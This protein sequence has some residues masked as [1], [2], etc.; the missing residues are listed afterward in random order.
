MND[1]HSHVVFGVDDGAK[2]EEM[3]LNMI[4]MAVASGTK[5]LIATPHYVRGRFQVSRGEI[6]Q[7]IDKLRKLVK[8][9]GIKIEIFAGQEVYYSESILQYYLEGE[10]GTIEDTRYM[11]VELP[12]KGFEAEQVINSFYELQLKGVVIVLA[13]P[14]RYEEFIKRPELINRFVE[15]GFLFQLNTGSISGE[16]GKEVKKTAELFLKHDIYSVIGSDAHRLRGRNTDMRPGAEELK[17]LKTGS[18]EDYKRNMDKILSNEEIR[19]LGNRIDG[20]KG[21][22]GIIKKLFN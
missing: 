7:E 9:K 18:V 10:I 5:K 11:L 20:I 12:I 19:C 3:A 8:D 21:F 2:N 14:E 6:R 15:E 17:R 13:H 22:K 16:F 4:E 1:F